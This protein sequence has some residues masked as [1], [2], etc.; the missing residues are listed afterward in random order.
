MT[1]RNFEI[2][3]TLAVLPAQRPDGWQKELN[4]ISWYGKE[5]VYDLRE[6]NK[7][8]SRMSKGITLTKE[9]LSILKERFRPMH[10]ISDTGLTISYRSGENGEAI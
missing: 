3:E 9:E 1:D 6:W 5:P 2:K 10:P 8:H 4:L 7:D